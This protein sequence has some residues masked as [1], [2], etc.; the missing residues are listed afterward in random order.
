[1]NHEF[2]TLAGEGEAEIR[3]RGSRFLAFAFPATNEAE[4]RNSL[5]ERT[6][7]YFDATHH[8]AGWR[9]RDGSWRALDAGEPG[10]SAGAPIVAA[11]QGAGLVDAAVV[12]TRWFGGTKLGVGG[13]VR[14]Y[15]DAAA[16]AIAD[17]PRARGVP[18]QRVVVRYAYSQTPAVM[19][20]L[21][22][23]STSRIEYGYERGGSGGEVAFVLPTVEV[24]ALRD[25][26]REQ[27]AGGVEPRIVAPC[28]LY[29]SASR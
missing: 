12:V 15:G 8:C 6:R 25:L 11:L 22:R 3:E 14:A 16:A 5:A 18:A 20:A 29:Y 23:L 1:M 24:E 7:R 2:L 17:A 21:E 19:R 10:G 9:F 27:T 28:V 13:L 26:L 4:A